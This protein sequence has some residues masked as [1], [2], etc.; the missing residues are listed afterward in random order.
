MELVVA[1]ESPEMHLLRRPGELLDLGLVLFIL[2]PLFFKA[3]LPLFEKEAV[4]AAVKLGF[5]VHQLDAALGHHVEKVTVMT[6]GEDGP[7]E[8]QQIVFQP[9]HGVEIQMVRRLVEQQDLRV[10]KDQTGKIQTGFLSAGEA[11][12]ALRP[13]LG[14]DLK[15]V[16]HTVY[17]DVRFI[18]PEA[19]IIRSEAVVLREQGGG[20]VVFHLFRQLFHPFPDGVDMTEGILEHV[21]GGPALRINRQLGNEAETLGGGDADLALIVV[22][23]TGQNAEERRLAAA[24]G[25]EDPD[26]LTRFHLETEPVKNIVPDFEGFDQGGHGDVDHRSVLHI[27]AAPHGGLQNGICDRGSY[28]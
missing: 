11:F 18:T 24:V 19:L 8:V 4:V 26:T 28:G 10:L 5:P 14:T 23:R 22:Q 16:G 1:H 3:A 2:F 12:K 13:H 25:T 27:R 21:L 17:G 9:F 7:L 20:T 15:P 6:D